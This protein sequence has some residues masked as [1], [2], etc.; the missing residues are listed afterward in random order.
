[1]VWTSE[2]PEGLL[3]VEFT[4]APSR[5]ALVQ[6]RQGPS[7]VGVGGPHRGRNRGIEALSGL[8]TSRALQNDDDEPMMTE[9]DELIPLLAISEGDA[10][11]DAVRAGGPAAPPLTAEDH[12]YNDA[13]S[14]GW[15]DHGTRSRRAA[16]ATRGA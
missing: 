5:D 14:E 8:P 13:V 4:A 11:V 6:T 12:A 2:L 16:D 3:G 10:S 9:L 7:A 15:P 1:V